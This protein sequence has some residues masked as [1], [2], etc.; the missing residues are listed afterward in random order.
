[1]ETTEGWSNGK[2]CGNNL[3]GATK[4][5]FYGGK[6]IMVEAEGEKKKRNTAG[7]RANGLGKMHEKIIEASLTHFDLDF[8]KQVNICYSIYGSKLYTDFVVHGIPK[9]HDGLAIE[10]KYQGSSGSAD[11]KFPYLIHNIKEMFPI[12]CIILYSLDGARSKSVEWLLKQRGFPL[13]EILKYDKF[14]TLLH[15]WMLPYD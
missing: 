11:E 13:I 8:K 5:K 6:K 2:D 10:S 4:I 7:G 3:F 14:P 9:F 15:E 1:M 12:P